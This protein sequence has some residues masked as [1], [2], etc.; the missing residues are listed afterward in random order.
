M[1]G[2]LLHPGLLVIAE[3]DS[4][5]GQQRLLA[6]MEAAATLRAQLQEAHAFSQGAEDQLKELRAQVTALK[7]ELSASERSLGKLRATM[8]PQ[9]HCSYLYYAG[10]LVLARF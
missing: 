3:Q 9:H 8:P 4:L 2:L 1:R 6:S 5:L 10:F 7:R